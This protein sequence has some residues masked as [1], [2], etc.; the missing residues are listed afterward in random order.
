MRTKAAR[1]TLQ[2]R[3]RET[4]VGAVHAQLSLGHPRALPSAAVES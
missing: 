3:L 4:S 2:S 1:R